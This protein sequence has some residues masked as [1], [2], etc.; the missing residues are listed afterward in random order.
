M[1][2]KKETAK[3]EVG[4]QEE[5][6]GLFG[7]RDENL[8]YIEKEM[9]VRLTFRNSEVTV[10]G[11]RAA[12]IVE[13]LQ[14][15]LEGCRRGRKVS[16]SDIRYGLMLLKEENGNRDLKADLNIKLMD[17]SGRAIK[18]R[19]PR[20]R[21]YLEALVKSDMVF[22]IGP[23]GTG[24][25]YLAVAM[26]VRRLL[27]E[28]VKRIVVCRPAVEAGEKLGFL[29]GDFQQ[30]VDPYLRPIYD[31]LFGMMAADRCARML[32]R[33]II[34]V[35]PL[36]YMRGRTLDDAFVIM[37]EAQNTTIEQ[38]KMFLTRLG[39]HSRAVVTG[40][41]TQVDLPTDKVSGLIDA[42]ERLEGIKEIQFIYFSRHDVMRHDLVAK[43]IKAYENGAK[44]NDGEEG[45]H[46]S[47]D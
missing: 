1:P 24:K 20:Q 2:E 26:A 33:G 42:A 7:H 5:A 18:P 45:G 15:L 23:A 41:I 6:L 35:A 44:K 17:G 21:D 39:P 22:A 13:L 27:E 14:H 31:A 36:A 4:S 37:D 3:L 28:S 40:D 10:S 43:I 11:P 32:E 46:G 12:G 16:K 19:S 30:K 38:M 8:R 34:E 9:D 29:P 47:G 25:T